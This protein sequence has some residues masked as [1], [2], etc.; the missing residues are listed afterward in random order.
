MK[1][2]TKIRHHSLTVVRHQPLKGT[3]TP[4]TGKTTPHTRTTFL[5]IKKQNKTKN[6]KSNQERS[7]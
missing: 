6:L 3:T 2:G 1:L 5:V 7:N 4:H